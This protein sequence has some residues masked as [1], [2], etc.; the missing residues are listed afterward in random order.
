VVRI[1]VSVVERDGVIDARRG[2]R[3]LDACRSALVQAGLSDPS[4]RQVTRADVAELGSSWAGR[5]GI[6]GRR[7]A[8]LLVARNKTDP[9]VV[10]VS[11]LSTHCMDERPGK[12]RDAVTSCDISVALR[13]CGD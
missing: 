2:A 10:Y 3:V 7:P 13:P 4:V 5:L 1:V 12:R 6:P 9:G 8:W 11:E